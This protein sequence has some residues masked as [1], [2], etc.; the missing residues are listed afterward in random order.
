[1][2]QQPFTFLLLPIIILTCFILQGNALTSF[3]FSAS[4]TINYNPT[5]QDGWLHT[6]GIYVKDSQGRN[7]A[8]RIIGNFPWYFPTVNL[9]Q[10]AKAHGINVIQLGFRIPSNDGGLGFSFNYNSQ[11]N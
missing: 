9:I 7:V 8:M 2:K 6:D 5:P 11:I 4:G 3:T 1:M 10:N